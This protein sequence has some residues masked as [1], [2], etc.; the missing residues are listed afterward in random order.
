MAL[1]VAFYYLGR[2]TLQVV[3]KQGLVGRAKRGIEKFSVR[4]AADLGGDGS[5]AFED[6]KQLLRAA[7][8]VVTMLGFYKGGDIVV[9]QLSRD[10]RGAVLHVALDKRVRIPS[11]AKLT[12][13]LTA[14]LYLV[15][16]EVV[17]SGSLVT[18][19]IVS[20]HK[21]SRKEHVSRLLAADFTALAVSPHLAAD[22]IIQREADTAR[23]VNLSDRQR[24]LSQRIVR[25]P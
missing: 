16:H 14:P 17:P 13:H 1:L 7:A 9:V 8:L 23:I 15:D 22:S 4:V 25:S 21:D 19:T 12:G 6:G 18:G 10:E 24:I 5:C 11:G 20:T 3:I 2:Q